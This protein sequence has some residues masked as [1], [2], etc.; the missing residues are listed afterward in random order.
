MS[1]EEQEAAYLD[2]MKRLQGSVLG[3]QLVEPIANYVIALKWEL[4]GTKE[5]LDLL[6][7][8]INKLLDTKSDQG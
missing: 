7:R 5:D 3:P 8:N 6:T 1:I 2:A 4:R